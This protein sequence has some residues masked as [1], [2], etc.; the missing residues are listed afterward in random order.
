MV[1]FD[2]IGVLKEQFTPATFSL[3]FA[4]QGTLDPIEHG[5]D[6]EPLA[7]IEEIAIVGAGRSLDLDVLA[8]RALALVSTAVLA[9]F[10]TASLVLPAHASICSRS[11][12]LPC[13][14]GGASLS[15][16]VADRARCHRNERSLRP[17]FGGGNWPIPDSRDSALG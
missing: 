17:P 14:G 11:S 1:N 9:G 8:V 6:F 3:L 2:D 7:P 10:G 16:L 12:V 5:M 13:W 4:Q 15:V